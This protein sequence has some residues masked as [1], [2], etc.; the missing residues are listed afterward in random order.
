MNGIS[1]V[2]CYNDGGGRIV[3]PCWV[4]VVWRTSYFSSFLVV[5]VGGNCEPFCWP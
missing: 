5:V 2:C 4:D 3:H 1:N